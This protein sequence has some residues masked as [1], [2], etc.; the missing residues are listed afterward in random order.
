MHGDD[1]MICQI[2]CGGGVLYVSADNMDSKNLIQN[3]CCLL[4]VLS[5]S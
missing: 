1:E 3:E 2:A 4:T 5:Q